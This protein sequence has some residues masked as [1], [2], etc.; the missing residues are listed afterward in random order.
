MIGWIGMFRSLPSNS[1]DL[2]SI[3][4]YNPVLSFFKTFKTCQQRYS[5]YW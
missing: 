5:H 4:K 2:A 3:T 1:D